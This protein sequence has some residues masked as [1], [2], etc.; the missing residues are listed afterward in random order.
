MNIPLE[1]L[2][3]I[4]KHGSCLVKRD[5]LF[6]VAG[7]RGGKARTCWVLSQGAKGL[8]TAG[9]RHSPQINIV[10]HIGKELGLNVKVF[11]GIGELTPELKEAK[12]FGVELYQVK[13]AYNSVLIA[14]AKSKALETGYTYIPFGMECE[15]AVVQTSKQVENIPDEVKR[16]VVP[17]GSGMSLAG[18]L[19][20]L[21]KFKKEHIKVLG[22]IVGAKP[23]KRLDKYAPP[24]WDKMV[25][26]RTSFL[27]YNETSPRL[28]LGDLVLDPIYE[29][30]CLPYLTSD[31]LLWVVGIRNRV[32]I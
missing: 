21:I 27:R 30:K 2:T 13:P 6:E 14:R 17:V 9:A 28:H 16:I 1:Y 7:V 31:D 10:A 22:I 24:N 8:V 25:E 26:F 29:S 12:D 18:I 20:G 4:E 3:P 5:D 11:T 15:E 32:D 23:F 19:S